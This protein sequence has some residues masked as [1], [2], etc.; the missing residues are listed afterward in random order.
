MEPI[1]RDLPSEIGPGEGGGRTLRGLIPYDAPAV[2]HEKGKTFREVIRRGAFARALGGAV[3]VISTF[4]HN[5]NRLLGRTSSGTLR[6]TDTPAG[7]VYVVDLPES[8]EDV[9]EL[10]ARRDLRGS[11]FF[12]WPLAGGGEKWTAPAA[13]G[14]L[15][16]RELLGLEMVELGP[17]VMPAYPDSNA[18]VRSAGPGGPAAGGALA[19]RLV[20]LMA[21]S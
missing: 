20:G 2:I 19:A 16:L 9:R 15:P 18:E 11:S 10:L 13:R 6:L 17:V 7:L 8:A 3:D 1:R 14:G 4:N 12:A 5:P 21:R